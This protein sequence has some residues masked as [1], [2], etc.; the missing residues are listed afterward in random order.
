MRESH[1]RR[2][3]RGRILFAVHAVAPGDG[4]SHAACLSRALAVPKFAAK[5]PNRPLHHQRLALHN[6]CD[7]EST[8]GKI[9]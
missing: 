6:F 9:A 1:R 8:P 7:N 3:F 4:Q 5:E 2:Q